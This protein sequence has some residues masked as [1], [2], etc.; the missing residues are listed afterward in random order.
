MAQDLKR[1]AA[2][3]IVWRFIGNGGTQA[4]LFVSGVYIARILSP[5]DYGLMGMMAIFL[6]ISQ[7]FINSG[8]R[9]VLI[10]KGNEISHDHYNVVFIFNVTVSIL[11]YGFIFVGAPFI[12]DFYEQPRL[13][14]IARVLGLNLVF[15]ALGLVHQT[16]QEKRL[17]FKTVAKVRL[18]A[19][20]AS[21]AV[22][23]TMA[24]LHYG[25][26]AL[27]AMPLVQNLLFSVLIWFFNKWNP[28]FSFNGK[29]FKELFSKS[30]QIFAAGL[31]GAISNNIYAM[32]IGKTFAVADVGFFRQG[33]KLKNNV[34]SIVL[35][36]LQ[37]VMFPVLAL[38]KDDIPRL[39][40]SIRKN[41]KVSTLILFPALIGLMAV[42]EPF[43]FIFLGE[44]WMPSVYF[45]QVLS[46]A[47][48]LFIVRNIVNRYVLPMGR[49][50]LN[51]LINILR[52]SIFIGL[53]LLG[54]LIKLELKILVLGTIIAE[55]VC[56]I[57]EVYFAKK[58]I[59]YHLREI[60][61]D[62]APALVF[63]SVMGL[64]VWG[65]GNRLGISLAVLV[66]QI[67]AG[68]LIYTLLNYWFN[69]ALFL[70]IKNMMLVWV[71]KKKG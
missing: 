5:N 43:M 39:K 61:R 28:T 51:L 32:V 62:V 64:V 37:S 35:T 68:G 6:G 31:L 4:I 49:F 1:D 2:R 33:E 65:V 46:L 21:V 8:F 59:N 54:V 30:I 29:I 50:K 23:I 40:N 67:L 22:G 9:A 38:M 13:L 34:G 70:E 27:V 20:S 48:I 3:G 55:A 47:Y 15:T 57:W 42:A 41:S 12:A 11:F 69:R 24:T 36:S 25:V 45:L 44:K 71:K 58:Y 18:V 56:L 66:I 53:L 7:A 63:S 52:N 14:P 26:W 10:Q 16:I 19:I 60:I 17:N